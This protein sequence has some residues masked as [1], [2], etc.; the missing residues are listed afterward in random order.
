LKPLRHAQRSS[1]LLALSSQRLNI[2]RTLF[3]QLS[4]MTPLV[5]TFALLTTQ[6]QTTLV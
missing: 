1:P 5:N 4:E 6:L 3:A 2:S